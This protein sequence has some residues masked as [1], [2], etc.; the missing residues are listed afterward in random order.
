MRDLAPAVPLIRYEHPAPGDL[1]HLDIKQLGRFAGVIS[2]PDGRRRGTLHRVT[3]FHAVVF[4][5]KQFWQ[6]RRVAGFTSTDAM[7]EAT[8]AK[9][10][11]RPISYLAAEDRACAR[12]ASSWS[13]RPRA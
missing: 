8:A 10:A 4:A 5:T 3:P 1:L 13:A 9:N 6:G 2:R 11:A 12:R 7:A